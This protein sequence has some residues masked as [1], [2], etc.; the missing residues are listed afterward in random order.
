MTIIDGVHGGGRSGNSALLGR[1]KQ[2]KA[3]TQPAIM[4]PMG[5][6]RCGSGRRSVSEG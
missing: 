5:H 1:F 2:P 3:T 6:R 4:R